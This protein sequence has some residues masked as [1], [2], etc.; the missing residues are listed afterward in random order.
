MSQLANGDGSGRQPQ[1]YG[2]HSLR[3][4]AVSGLAGALRYLQGGYTQEEAAAEAGACVPY[5]TA[6]I[7]IVQTEDAK[8]IK[9]VLGGELPVLATAKEVK[10]RAKATAGYRQMSTADKAAF[11]SIIGPGELWDSAVA[12]AIR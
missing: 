12:P 4:A 2:P 6:M 5:V 10:A 9:A 7:P 8:L 11:G 1:P 3:R